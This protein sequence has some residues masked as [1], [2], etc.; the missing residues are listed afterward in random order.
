MLGDNGGNNQVAQ[1]N[2]CIDPGQYGIAIAGGQYNKVLRNYIVS[3]S[4]PWTNVGM[5]VMP[6]R[7][8]NVNH[9]TFA[10]N[11]VYWKNRNGVSNIFWKASGSGEV[12]V[13]NTTKI[14]YII[15]K[16]PSDIGLIQ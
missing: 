15:P 10:D 6:W 8:V 11:R 16:K 12:A 3:E 1:D 13:V 4:H 9:S 7:G 2:F 14:Q 5:F